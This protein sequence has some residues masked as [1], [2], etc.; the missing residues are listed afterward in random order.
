MAWRA[1]GLQLIARE[2]V[3][4]RRARRM[5][6]FAEAA[7]ARRGAAGPASP[8]LRPIS[9]AAGGG[10]QQI[11]AWKCRRPT[12]SPTRAA[13]TTRTARIWPVSWWAWRP[14]AL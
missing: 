7:A 3:T 4:R 10:R 1:G 14:P 5:L 12:R 6:L 13:M 8:A 2:P 9:R 11:V